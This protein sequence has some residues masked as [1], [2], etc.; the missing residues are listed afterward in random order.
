MIP[1]GKAALLELVVPDDEA[2]GAVV[3]GALEVVELCVLICPV[4]CGVNCEKPTA[5][6]IARNT[7][8]SRSPQLRGD[9]LNRARIA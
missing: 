4:I 3:S 8:I 7:P 5:G 2:G 6:N 1:A 9:R